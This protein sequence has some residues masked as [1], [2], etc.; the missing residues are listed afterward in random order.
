MEILINEGS[1]ED[2]V[3][4][5]LRIPEF[6]NPY[7]QEIYKNRLVKSPLLLVAHVNEVQAG[8]KV[9]YDRDGDGMFYNW[10]EGVL[11]DFRGQ[12]VAQKL[13]NYQESW[14]KESGFKGVSVKTRNRH[15]NM[16]HF[17]VKNKYYI[18]NI[19]SGFKD[20]LEYR[21]LFEKLF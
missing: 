4:L 19:D 11:P 16:I 2:V 3:R 7:L 5:S 21:V 13:L 18:I 17:L 6:K 8:F 20:P 9:G 15:R 10:M 1:I 12:G 14:V